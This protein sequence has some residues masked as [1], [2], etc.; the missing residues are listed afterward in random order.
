MASTRKLTTKSGKTFYEIRV[1]LSR[2]RSEL[3]TRWYP[4]TGWS[5]RSIQ[6]ELARQAAEFERRCRAGEVFS[7]AERQAGKDAAERKITVRRYGEEVFMPTKS[8]TCSENTRYTFQRLLEKHV[9][10]VLGDIF[11]QEVTAAQINALLLDYQGSGAKHSS[12]LR[13]YGVLRLLFK[14]AYLNDTLEKNP[15]DKVPRPRPRKEEGKPPDVEA[16]T[17]EEIR[18]ILACLEK[19]PLKWQALIRL[20]IDTGMRRGEVCGLQ[21]GDLNRRENTLT[22]SRTLNYTA[23]QGIY[24]STTKNGRQRVIDVDPSVMAL[25]KKLRAERKGRPG[26]EDFVFTRDDS[27]QPLNPLAANRYMRRFGERFGV[28]NMHPHKLRHTFASIALTNGADVVSISRILGHSDT[29]V[30]LRVYAHSDAESR[31][32]ASKVFRDALQPKGTKTP[33]KG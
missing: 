16:F 13:V 27:G 12:C 29:A 32:R 15:M 5:E 20:M 28:E 10:P 14:M 1:H 21:W 33:S 23:D 18:Y 31:K 19:E 3:T 6:R 11:L 7:R 25:L 30:T 4:P 17:V 2:D 22:V 26:P 8:I 9:Y 24:V